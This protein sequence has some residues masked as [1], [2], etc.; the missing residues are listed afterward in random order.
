M[1]K[2]NRDQTEAQ[3]RDSSFSRRFMKPSGELAFQIDEG[4]L[5]P[6]GTATWKE[7]RGRP[8]DAISE[9]LHHNGVYRQAATFKVDSELLA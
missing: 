7:S 2:P 5:L 8:L 9:S 1:P 4:G 6:L 3:V